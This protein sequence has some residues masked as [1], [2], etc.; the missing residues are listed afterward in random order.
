[1]FAIKRALNSWFA[2]GYIVAFWII[3]I[4]FF[5][6]LYRSLEMTSCLLPGSTHPICETLEAEQW[7][8]VDG[9]SRSKK[10]NNIYLWNSCWF[11]F[12]TMTTVGYFLYHFPSGSALISSTFH[13]RAQLSR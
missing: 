5:G 4:L 7:A 11:I 1:M 6:Y 12:I 13:Y 2:M 10:T 3:L 9:A 8:S